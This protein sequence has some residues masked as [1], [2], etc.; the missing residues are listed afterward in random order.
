[1]KNYLLTFISMAIVSIACG[2]FFGW[3]IREHLLYLANCC[4]LHKSFYAMI[5]VFSVWSGIAFI[6]AT[7]WIV[8]FEKSFDF[9][10]SIFNIATEVFIIVTIAWQ[11]YFIPLAPISYVFHLELL[12]FIFFIRFFII[13]I[14][15]KI[16]RK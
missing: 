13:E 16:K 15:Q 12:V 14:L 5:E 4:P 2:S 7:H 3:L 11:L 1:M 8:E 9:K 10:L 6:I